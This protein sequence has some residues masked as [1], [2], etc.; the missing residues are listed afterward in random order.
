MPIIF[1]RD[2]ITFR[3]INRENYMEA[4]CLKLKP[5]QSCFVADNARSIAEAVYEEGIYIRGIYADD[6]MVGFVLYDYDVEIPGWSMSRFMIGDKY[7]GKGYGKE[8]LQEFLQYMK[9]T[10]K[11]SKLYVSVELN[12]EPALNMYR[13]AEF[14]YVKNMEYEFD[15]VV[16]NEIQMVKKL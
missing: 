16:Y 5:E 10:M 6:I 3:K 7:Q 2:M 1:R 8:A 9:D 11:I 4:I 14:M 15:G 12:N 13:S